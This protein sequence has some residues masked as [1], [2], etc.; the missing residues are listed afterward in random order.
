L[1]WNNDTGDYTTTWFLPMAL[2]ACIV[3]MA[4]VVASIRHILMWRADSFGVAVTLSLIAWIF[5]F[6]AMG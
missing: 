1:D 2:I 6:V 4:S 5:D 3:G